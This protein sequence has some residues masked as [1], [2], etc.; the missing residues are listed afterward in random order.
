ML[1]NTEVSNKGDGFPDDGD[2][3]DLLFQDEMAPT[4]E[5]LEIRDVRDVQNVLYAHPL[6]VPPEEIEMSLETGEHEIPFEMK[7]SLR[8]RK[9]FKGRFGD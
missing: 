8:M 2:E 1:Q 3:D 6:S 7:P 4:P 9:A 5:I